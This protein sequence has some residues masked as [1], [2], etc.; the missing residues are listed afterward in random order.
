MYF[1]SAGGLTGVPAGFN[2]KDRIKQLPIK[3][4]LMSVFWNFMLV[5]KLNSRHIMRVLPKKLILG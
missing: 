5:V 1:M 4:K 2:A 3:R